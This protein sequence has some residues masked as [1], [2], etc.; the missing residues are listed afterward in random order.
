MNFKYRKKLIDQLVEECSADID[1][2]KMTYNTNYGFGL[3]EKACKTYM[4]YVILQIIKRIIIMSI[5]GA[6][7][8][9]L[10][11]ESELCQCIPEADLGLLQHPRWSAL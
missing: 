7:F 11:Y 2:N 6:R 5:S 4:L 9:L 1:G 10:V 3:N 8:F